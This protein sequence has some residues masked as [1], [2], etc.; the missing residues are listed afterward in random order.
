MVVGFL[1]LSVGRFGVFVGSGTGELVGAGSGELVGSG[2]CAVA[3][4]RGCAVAS[5]TG[6][7]VEVAGGRG[8]E[9]GCGAMIGVATLFCHR[10]Y[11]GRY[12]RSLLGQ[13]LL[14]AQRGPPLRR[15]PARSCPRRRWSGPLTS[16]A[17]LCRSAA[18]RQPPA[19]FGRNVAMAVL[20]A[21]ANGRTSNSAAEVAAAC[22]SGGS[23]V[24]GR[25]S[26][27]SEGRLSW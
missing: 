17:A 4:G 12:D 25:L 11:L 18:R 15:A 1:G 13:I 2:C 6:R 20:N 14:A 3:I 8:V 22:A 16:S 21:S 23:A 7:G 24:L 19:S 10:V 9:L 5:A 26:W 27:L